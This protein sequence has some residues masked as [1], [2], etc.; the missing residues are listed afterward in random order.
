MSRPSRSTRARAATIAG[1]AILV[2]AGGGDAPAAEWNPGLSGSVWIEEGYTDNLRA[3][4]IVRNEAFFTALGGE[5]QWRRRKPR[6]WLPHWFGGGIDGRMYSKYSSHDYAEFGP[7]FG[8]DWRRLSMAVEYDYSPDHLR[9]DPSASIPAFADDH[10][11]TAEFRSKFGRNRRWMAL[12]QLDSRWELYGKDYE[13]RTYFQE[14]IEA[15]LRWRA[16]DRFTPRA[17]VVYTT[18]DADGP[19]YDLDQVATLLGFDVSLPSG[20]RAIFRYERK[21]RDYLVGSAKDPT[22]KKNNNFDREDDVNF[23]EAGFDVPFPWVDSATIQLRYRN[24]D[25]DSSRIDRSYTVNEAGLRLVYD[26]E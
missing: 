9:V 12:L 3:D 25:N 18:R 17:S 10:D 23:F 6:G 13:A 20:I 11:L 24:R 19:N 14:E 7:A 21:W 1:I 2:L 4:R 8:Y 22:G 15:G 5:A 16:T 26:F